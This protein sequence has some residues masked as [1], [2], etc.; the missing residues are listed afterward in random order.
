MSNK[1]TV[2]AVVV[3]YNRNELLIECLEALLN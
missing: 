2:C 1:E 3:T